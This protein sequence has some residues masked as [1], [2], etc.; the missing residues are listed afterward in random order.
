MVC[1]SI[2]FILRKDNFRKK[3]AAAQKMACT[4]HEED[5]LGGR[6]AAVLGE[7]EREKMGKLVP[8]PPRLMHISCPAA[9]WDCPPALCSAPSQSAINS[10]HLKLERTNS[11]RPPKRPIN[12][13]A[14]A[15]FL[16]MEQL[17]LRRRPA[18]PRPAGGSRSE[19]GAAG[20][21]LGGQDE[22]GRGVT[23]RRRRRRQN[24]DT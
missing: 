1:A 8:P 23:R 21:T 5:L 19:G 9:D 4:A 10:L 11:E 3:P 18:W 16:R 24:G 14:F 12:L 20:V 2:Q 7:N 17:P 13:A 15:S 6:F 22:I